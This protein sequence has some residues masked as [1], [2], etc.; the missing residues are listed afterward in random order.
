MKHLISGLINFTAAS[1]L[2]ASLTACG[3]ADERKVKYLEKGKAY[4]EQK[5]Y[6]KARIEFKNVLQIDPK[7]AEAYFYMGQLNER[8]KELS[9]AFANYKKAIELD[10]KHIDAKLKLAKIY[11][12][13]GTKEYISEANKL[14]NQVRQAEPKNI[15]AEFVAAVIGYKTEDK[16]QGVIN[17]EKVVL[18]DNKLVEGISLLAAFYVAEGDE[19]KAE[20]LLIE[21]AKNNPK[22]VL[23]R[24]TLAKILA[25]NSKL[26]EAENYLKQ[27]KDIEPDKYSLQ[28]ALASFYATSNQIDKAES[29][30]RESIKQDDE[31]V[32]RYLVFVEMLSSRV[33]VKRANE[34]L[35]NAIKNKPHL[36]ELKF[37]QVLFYEKLGKKSDAKK[38]L[39]EIIKEKTFDV[40]GVK[41][42]NMLAR[43]LLKEGDLTGATV[44]INEVISEYPNNNDALLISSKMALINLDALTAINGLR[45]VVKNNPKNS[46]ASLLLAQAHELNKESGLAENELKKSIEANPVNDKVHI[47]YANYLASKGRVDEAVDV[48][49]KALTYFKNN[50][51]LMNIKLKV[52]ASQ[53]KAE[54][55]LILLNLMEQTNSNIADVNIYKGQY[56]LSK[57]EFSQATKEFEKAYLKSTDKYKP[58]QLIVKAYMLNKKPEAALKRLNEEIADNNAIANLLIGQ[59]YMVQKK[60]PEARKKFLQASKAAENWFI[61]YSNL[62]AT[63]LSEKKYEKAISIYQNSINKLRN[64]SP[65]QMQI[66]A[67]HEKQK[68][69]L[70]AMKVYQSVLSENKSNKLAANNYASLLLDYGN[71][72]D[73][74]KAL[75]LT[76]SFEKMPQPA[77]QDTLAWA[78]V[79]KG[80]SLK[81]IEILKPIVE[82]APKIAVFRYHLGYALYEMG[83][84]AAAKSHLEIA[85]TSKQEFSGKAKA[86]ELYKSL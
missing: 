7:Y 82:K 10:P 84:K 36:Y 64:A 49:D 76:K 1:I 6:D 13:G 20:K 18:K 62:A 54:E 30:L 56:Y 80:N 29:V 37:S 63:Y 2:A 59:I 61:P 45:T 75:E 74:T 44:L 32:Q 48:V 71:A 11:V 8:K 35:E 16:A 23:L 5:N 9:K 46:D 41:A 86:Q 68:K 22:S 57:G 70:K 43:I 73:V 51:D 55:V 85:T 4:I 31:D 77:L 78:Y 38:I 81:A 17:L 83:D 12:V 65:A 67:I 53:N 28:V 60:L 33:S 26:V 72:S 66:A 14:I 39:K 19:G 15:E 21:G 24:V 50:Y 40:E 47:N 52:I 69:Y 27:A 34:E 3:G 25:K 58:L 79:K 42:R